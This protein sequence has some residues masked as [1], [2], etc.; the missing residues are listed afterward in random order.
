LLYEQNNV[1]NVADTGWFTSR[2]VPA[3]MDHRTTVSSSS[4]CAAELHPCGDRFFPALLAVCGA[5]ISLLFAAHVGA[6]GPLDTVTTTVNNVTKSVT[7]TA[8]D[9][10]QTVTKTVDTT[11]RTTVDTAVGGASG[12]TQVGRSVTPATDVASHPTGAV[13]EI[14]RTVDST[15]HEVASDGASTAQTAGAVGRSVDTAMQ[16]TAQQAAHI[17]GSLIQSAQPVVQT[18][19]QPVTAITQPATQT[20]VTT[21]APAAQAAAPVTQT[22]NA[23]VATVTQPVQSVTKPVIKRATTASAPVLRTAAPVMQAA[24][25]VI[26]QVTAPIAQTAAT[27]ANTLAAPTEPVIAPAAQ[28]VATAVAPIVTS[29]VPTLQTLQSVTAPVAAPPP[30]IATTPVMTAITTIAPALRTMVADA[31]HRSIAPASVAPVNRAERP[32]SAP[33]APSISPIARTVSAADTAPFVGAARV[34]TPSTAALSV[35]HRAATVATALRTTLPTDV[36]GTDRAA[37]ASSIL[38]A[39]IT[40]ARGG[41]SADAPARMNIA[42]LGDQSEAA[43]RIAPAA[44]DAPAF[45]SRLPADGLATT[46]SAA[47]TSGGPGLSLLL[48]LATA[49]WPLVLTGRRLVTSALHLSQLTYRPLVSPG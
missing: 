43:S 16:P 35:V 36:F 14:T 41:G 11:V 48:A 6:A 15:T 42:P 33:D 45:P 40:A 24:A 44:P 49:G 46:T 38:P 9:T 34:A 3:Q 37:T 22:V 25:P 13:T 30:M 8:Q 17:A 26:Q 7:Q 29:I 10:T 32:L 4:E 20:I 18:V 1:C 12:S 31:G 39:W 28:T 19:A 27:A 23:T 5:L 47:G 2:D 21:A